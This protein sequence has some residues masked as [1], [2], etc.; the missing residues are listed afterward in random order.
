MDFV[1]I[2]KDGENE[3]LR[4]SIRS[5]LHFFPDAKIW[6]VGGKP[7]WY[8]GN[9]IPVLQSKKNKY[10]NARNNLEIMCKH[11]EISNSFIL[12]NDDFYI[13]KSLKKIKAYHG[14]SM[15]ERIDEYQKHMGITPYIKKLKM[16]YKHLVRIGI[17]E[18]LDYALHVPMPME[19]DKLLYLLTTHRYAHSWR[20]LYGNYYKLGGEEIRDVKVYDKKDYKPD[21]YDHTRLIYPFLSSNDDSF[22]MLRKKVLNRMFPRKTKLEKWVRKH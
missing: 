2:C 15:Y 20:S 9:H 10:E 21:P 3:E 4:Y 7:D 16:T 13:V 22:E 6:V 17:R 12:M 11:K 18:P 5:V 14:G 1:Y 8:I 19:R